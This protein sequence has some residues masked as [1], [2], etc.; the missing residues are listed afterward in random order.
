MSKKKNIFY[1][2][3]SKV[4]LNYG[5][6]TIALVSN[7]LKCIQVKRLPMG[8]N[9]S[10]EAEAIALLFAI[11]FLH[12]KNF[13]NAWINSDSLRVVN[14]YGIKLYAKERGI[15]IYWVP[16][17]MNKNADKYSRQKTNE[18]IQWETVKKYRKVHLFDF[19]N[20]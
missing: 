16:R 17:E 4:S 18:N 19:R 3:A 9:C 2:D 5:V 15:I 13:K 11:D 20:T 7:S 1:V 10:N 8:I 6:F 12:K 14:N